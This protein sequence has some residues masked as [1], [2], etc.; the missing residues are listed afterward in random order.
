VQRPKAASFLSKAHQYVQD[1]P[2]ID[3]TRRRS[4]PTTILPGSGIYE[5]SISPGDSYIDPPD[6]VKYVRKGR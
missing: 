5:P 3:G 4:C 1:E 6:S 2:L